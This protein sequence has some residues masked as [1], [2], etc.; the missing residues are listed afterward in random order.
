MSHILC[1]TSGY[2]EAHDALQK[3]AAHLLSQA[4]FFCHVFGVRLFM[5]EE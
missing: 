4:L 5:Q 3:F 2:E 1:L